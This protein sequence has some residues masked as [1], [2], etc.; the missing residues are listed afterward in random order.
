M[1]KSILLFA[2]YFLCACSSY[3][4]TDQ[5]LDSASLFPDHLPS[6]ICYLYTTRK[7]RVF[8]FES[9]W[10]STGILFDGKHLITAGHNVYD[11]LGTKL[12][13]VDV[14][15]KTS[16]GSIVDSTLNRDDIER[17][18]ENKGYV[19]SGHSFNYDYSFLKLSKELPV[20]ESL[21]LSADV[22]IGADSPIEVAGYPGGKLVYKQGETKGKVNNSLMAYKF[23][24]FKGMSGGPVWATNNGTVYLVGVHVKNEGARVVD[25][26]LLDDYKN[27][28]DRLSGQ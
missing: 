14:F 4:T 8:G 26:V 21:S 27:W 10:H 6:N 22:L 12:H 15:C 18:R 20:A 7:A 1:K 11:S 19:N 13:K 9:N 2:A 28:K 23:E 3:T 25:A 16:D 5:E 24:T 17:T